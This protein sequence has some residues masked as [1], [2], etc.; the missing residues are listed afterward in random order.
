MQCAVVH[1]KSK[2]LK[3]AISEWPRPK[4]RVNVEL[5][6]E[7]AVPLQCRHCEDAPCVKVCPSKALE[8][9]Q[10]ESPV[11]IKDELCIGCKWCILVCPYGVI[12][13]DKTG[14][15]LIKCDFCIERLKLGEEP[16]CVESCP[17]GALQFRSIKELPK[18]KEKEHLVKF[19][20]GAEII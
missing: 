3:Q 8:K 2:D 6:M 9:P 4:S 10:L 12:S 5:A 7:M 13:M 14:K 18:K 11:L 16:A 19:K 20:K 15:A 17:T 1:S